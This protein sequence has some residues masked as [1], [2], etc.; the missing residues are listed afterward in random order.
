MDV[1]DWSSKRVLVT[2]G[3]GFIGS[4]LSSKVLQLGAN[5]TVLDDCSSGDSAKVPPGANFI[6]GCITNPEMRESLLNDA[7]GKTHG[8]IILQMNINI[9]NKF[10]NLIVN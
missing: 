6:E 9:P 1:M 10:K 8:Q 2:G 7:Q 3:A 4:H 5:V